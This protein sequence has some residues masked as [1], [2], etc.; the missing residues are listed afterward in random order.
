[1]SYPYDL[2]ENM[3]IS[4]TGSVPTM[5][6]KKYLK[7]F[8]NLSELSSSKK[9]YC[10]NLY[11]F[12]RLLPLF[13]IDFLIKRKVKKTLIKENAPEAIQKLY[14]KIAEIII[15]SA[16]KNYGKSAEKCN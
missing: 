15:Y 13:L 5:E 4:E 2:Y 9:I 8:S 1:M 16:M 14:K 12:K 6:E 11:F 7:K 3:F 10:L